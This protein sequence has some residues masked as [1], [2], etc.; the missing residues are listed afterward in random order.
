MFYNIYSI[1][2]D[3]IHIIRNA[4]WD[5]GCYGSFFLEICLG[6]NTYTVPSRGK[7]ANFTPIQIPL[8]KMIEN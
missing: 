5:S 7:K 3:V 8:L 1:S 4:F 2:K 6:H